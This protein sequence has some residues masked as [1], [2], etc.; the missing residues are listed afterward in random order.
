MVVHGAA[1]ASDRFAGPA[2]CALPAWL[3]RREARRV[4]GSGAANRLSPPIILNSPVR[5]HLLASNGCSR[6]IRD[7]SGTRKYCLVS[8]IAVILASPAILR[9]SLGWSYRM[10]V[11]HCKVVAQRVISLRSV[12]ENRHGRGR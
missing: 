2:G 11:G 12:I 3:T 8:D 6:S 4:G 1:R 7:G 10:W 9:R 5:N